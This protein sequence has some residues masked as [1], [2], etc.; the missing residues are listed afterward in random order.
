MVVP[1]NAEGLKPTIS[2][3]KSLDGSKVLSFHKSLVEDRCV[4]LLVK[5]VGKQMPEKDVR[6]N[7]EALKIHVQDIMQLH[8]QQPRQVSHQGSTY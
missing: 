7:L 5:N 8:P 1:V 2:A 4:R 3:L 6:E